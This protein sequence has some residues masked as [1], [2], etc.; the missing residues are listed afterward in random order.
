MRSRP[1]Y[2][3]RLTAAA[4]LLAGVLSSPPV[5]AD[6]HADSMLN[7]LKK[8]P[9][10]STPESW[11]EE[12]REAA[13]ELGRLKDKR[14][15]PV[16]LGIVAKERFDVI[17]EIAID[18]LG[19][20]GDRRAVGPLKKLLNDPSLD[21]YV[22]D[23]VA[24]ALKKLGEESAAPEVQPRVTPRVLP[25]PTRPGESDTGE[26]T[27]ESREAPPDRDEKQDLATRLAKL[28]QP[29]GGLPPLDLQLPPDLVAW[30]DRWDL[31]AGSA[32]V[33][34]DKA[35][36]QTQGEVALWSR[37]RRQV[38]RRLWA[39]SAEGMFRLG[40]RGTDPQQTDGS[41]NLDNS[42]EL[43]PEIRIY[44][45]QRDVPLLFGQVSGSIGYGLTFSSH[46]L[47]FDRR[48]AVAGV[49]SVGGGP[50]YGRIFD[51]G[52]RLRLKRLVT[53]M[54]KAGALTGVLDRAVGDQIIAAW[55]Q[56]RNR[57]GTFQHL[58]Y[59]LDILQ[60]ANLLGKESIDPATTYRMIRIL[61]D[62]QLDDRRQGYMFRLGYGYARS[63]VEELDDTTMAFLYATGEHA[64]QITTARALESSLRFFYDMYGDPDVFGLTGQVG[65]TQYLYNGN[66]DPLGALSAF[67]SGG[68]NNQPGTRLDDGGL[69]YQVMLGGAYSRFFT[70]GSRLTA[71]AK[72]GYDTGSPLFLISIEAQYGVAYGS[73]APSE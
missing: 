58:G 56:L 31:A 63:M 7:I 70:R 57:I 21:A 19:E 66:L 48:L 12:R 18:A 13:R 26:G 5:R 39:Y 1:A 55:Y 32:N 44:P 61:D 53:V 33:R 20:I 50:G 8:R 49:I 35:A 69:G 27:P 22:R 64:W 71:S 2:V 11:L 36:G 17:L 73:F 72:I 41:W 3:L 34:W 16:L 6:E 45:F 52:A 62:P 24:G 46:P 42:L 28:Q 68:V 29:F 15:V 14:A 51:I 9:R 47:F 43:R 65:Y 59:T 4:L 23:A 54:K 10:G 25:K 60:R 30:S 38:E 67:L 40:F 37:V